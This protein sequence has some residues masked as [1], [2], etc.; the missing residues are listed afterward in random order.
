[1]LIM[2]CEPD[3]IDLLHEQS[4][5]GCKIDS[6]NKA[7]ISSNVSGDTGRRARQLGCVYFEKPFRWSGIAQWLKECEERPA[8]AREDC[9]Q[10]EDR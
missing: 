5:R 2:E 4:R 9:H 8:F 10:G 3:G 7:V 1:M 6:R